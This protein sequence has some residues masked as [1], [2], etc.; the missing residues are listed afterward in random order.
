MAFAGAAELTEDAVIAAA[1][2]RNP[3]VAQMAAAW[4]AATARYPQVTS[5]D[6]PRVGGYF[7][8]GSIG[9]PDVDF[10]Y[11]FEISQSF[12]YPGKRELRGRSALAPPRLRED[13]A[14]LQ[15]AGACA[16]SQKV[17]TP[18]R[19]GR[20]ENL[21]PYLCTLEQH[22]QEGKSM[23]EMNQEERRRPVSLILRRRARLFYLLRV[24]MVTW[25]AAGLARPSGRTVIWPVRTGGGSPITSSHAG[26]S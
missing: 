3:T 18:V 5:L 17:T 8:P 13:A 15:R 4:Q 21:S 14:G 9:S 19:L 1:L 23:N 6:D 26:S 2:A 24:R 22:R 12:P 11:R 7:G 16:G 20:N 10:A 25:P